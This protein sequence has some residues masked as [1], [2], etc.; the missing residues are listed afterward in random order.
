M[1]TVVVTDT[2]VAGNTA[3]TSITF[4]LVTSVTAPT[5]SLVSDTGSNTTDNLSNNGNLNFSSAGAGIARS[6]TV[7][8]SSVASYSVPSTDGVYTVVVTDT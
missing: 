4:S 3:S 2:D 7:N 6:Y 5:I 8:G 1:H